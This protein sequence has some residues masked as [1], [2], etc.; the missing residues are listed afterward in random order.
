MEGGDGREEEGGRS[1]SPKAGWDLGGTA[2][3][4]AFPNPLYDIVLLPSST[5]AFIYGNQSKKE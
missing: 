1:L 3:P 5:M 2:G 4:E